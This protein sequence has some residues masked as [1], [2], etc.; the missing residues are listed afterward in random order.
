MPEEAFQK[1]IP[2]LN[3]ALLLDPN[4]AF[5]HS[6]LGWAKMWFRWKLKEA[7]EEFLKG[8]QLDPSDINCIRGIFL[9]NLYL[10]DNDKAR[11]WREKG[12][13]VAPMIFG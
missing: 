1:S 11:F 6:N 5:A 8:N 2:L 10:G 12:L 9:L 13:A 4:L 7:E 3:K